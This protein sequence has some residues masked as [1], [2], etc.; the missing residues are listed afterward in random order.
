[1]TE[2]A[3]DGMRTVTLA[4][5]HD[6]LAMLTN[7]LNELCNGVALEDWEFVTRLGMSKDKGREL[8]AYLLSVL[9]RPRDDRDTKT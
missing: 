3:S 5:T 2:P 6:D 8:L 4:L 1:M 7:A 9:D